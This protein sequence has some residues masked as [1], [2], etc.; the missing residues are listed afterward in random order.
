MQQVC[1]SLRSRVRC[2]YVTATQDASGS[3]WRD[4][5]NLQV[6]LRLLIMR[7]FTQ[8]VRA[9]ACECVCACVRLC[10]W[11]RV[12]GLFSRRK[13]CQQTGNILITR[14]TCLRCS[15][16]PTSWSAKWGARNFLMNNFLYNSVYCPTA[17]DYCF[18]ASFGSVFKGSNPV[19]DS[20]HQTLAAARKIGAVVVEVPVGA[21]VGV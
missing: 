10:L 19:T 6:N 16:L 2:M 11:L 1:F 12:R 18:T 14:H 4:V 21:L 5:L 13:L 17:C 8:A 7:V 3:L 20:P 9:S 15:Q